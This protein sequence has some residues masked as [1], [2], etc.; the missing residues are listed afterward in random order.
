MPTKAQLESELET[1]R[2]RLKEVESASAS[3]TQ[4]FSSAQLFG[5]L[6]FAD[7]AIIS[8]DENFRI[9]F[10]NQGAEKIFGCRLW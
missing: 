1:L 8:I 6:Q 4:G 3:D 9:K 2:H 5:I 10:Y 7:D